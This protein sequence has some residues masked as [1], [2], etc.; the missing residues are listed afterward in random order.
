M[1]ILENIVLRK[2]AEVDARKHLN[3]NQRI[4]QQSALSTY[5]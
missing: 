1:T 5:Q 2:R 3:V 4:S